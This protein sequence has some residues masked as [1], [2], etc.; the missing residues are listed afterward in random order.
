MLEWALKAVDF[1][2]YSNGCLVTA[3][4]IWTKLMTYLVQFS[5]WDCATSKIHQIWNLNCTNL[6]KHLHLTTQVFVHQYKPSGSPTSPSLVAHNVFKICFFLLLLLKY[7]IV[8]SSVEQCILICGIPL[9]QIS[10]SIQDFLKSESIRLKLLI[11]SGFVFGSYSVKML[12]V[13]EYDVCWD[14]KTK[15]RKLVQ[16]KAFF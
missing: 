3:F 7:F 13:H 15:W 9:P 2:G 1:T 8:D 11:P 16:N 10:D 12:L 14:C 6:V 4:S 5:F